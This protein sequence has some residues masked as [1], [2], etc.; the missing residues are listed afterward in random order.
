MS[1]LLMVKAMSLKIGNPARKLVLLK[2][3]DNA[4]DQGVCFP[5]Y[6]YIADA[7]EISLRSA[8]EHIKVLIEMGLVSKKMRKNQ[9]GNQS[10]LYYLHLEKGG[11]EFAPPSAESAPQNAEICTTPSAESAPITSHSFNQSF[12][13]TSSSQQVATAEKTKPKFSDDDLKTA[14]WIFGLIQNLNPN[15]KKPS[16]ETWAKDVRL[17]RE[18]DKRTHREICELFQWANRDSFWQANILSPRKLREKW[19]QLVMKRQSQVSGAQ[20]SPGERERIGQSQ[21]G[22]LKGRILNIGGQ[23]CQ[24]E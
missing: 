8:K 13:H 15:A 23:Q 6:Q 21:K 17:L 3:A 10:N 18:V 1:M 24:V 4:N 14:Q 16:M 20:Q 7:C 11:A 2:L 9:D 22:W 12:N 5:S 19:D